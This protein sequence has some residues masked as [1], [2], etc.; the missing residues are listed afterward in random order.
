MAAVGAECWPAEEEK[1]FALPKSRNRKCVTSPLLHRV[2]IFYE[3][4]IKIVKKNISSDLSD[5]M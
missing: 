2:K 3:K 4:G 5:W 1:C